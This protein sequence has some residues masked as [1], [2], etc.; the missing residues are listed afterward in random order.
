MPLD[1]ALARRCLKDSDFNSLFIEGLGWDR[2]T[3]HLDVTVDDRTHSL[4]AVAQKR[5]MVAFVWQPPSGGRIP[6]YPTRRKVERKVAKSV[7]EHLIVYVDGAR[8]TQ[9][10]Q[11]VKREAGKPTACREHTYHRIQPGDALIQKLQ[12]LA[13]SIEDEEGLTLFAVTSGVRAGFDVEKV[14]KRFYDRFKTEH[15]AFTKFLKG[16]PDEGLQ[17]WYVSVM[18]N[19][20]MFIYF[21]QKKGFLDGDADY[22]RNK[23]AAS[24]DRGKDRYYRDFL[25]HLFFEGFAKRPQDRSA[26]TNRLLGQVPYLNGGLFLKHQIEEQ[27]GRT[28]EIPDR[29]FEKIFA[30]FDA[31]RWHLDERPLRRDDEINPDVLGYIFEKY[32]NQKQMG[33]YYTK[34]DITGYISQNTVIPRLFDMARAKCKVAFE[35]DQAVWRLLAADP[36]RYIYE[37]VRRGVIAEDGSIV[38]EKDLP[39]FVQKGMHDPKARLFDKRYNLGKAHIPPLPSAGEGG[40][41]GETDGPNLAL[42]TETWR[43]YVE[44]RK[45][46]LDLRRKIA[47]GEVHEI[48]DLITLNLDIRQFAQDVVENCEGPDL[49]VAFWNAIQGITVLDP[50][51]GSGA[52]LFAALNILEPLY[53]ACLDRM[54]AF[55]DEWGEAGRKR[56]PNYHKLFTETLARVA[57]HPSRRYFILKSIVIQNLYGVDIMDE[58]VEICKLRLFLKLVAQVD[59]PDR[60]EP[61][62]DID[63]NIRSGNTLVGFATYE[64]VKRAVESKF[65]FDKAL[66]KIEEKAEIAGRAFGMFRK[67]QTEQ[68]MKP[69]DFREAKKDLADRLRALD[70]ELNRYLAAEYAIE[71]TKAAEYQRWLDSHRPFHWFVDFYGIMKQGGFDVVIGNPPFVDYANV[72]GEYTVRNYATLSSGNLYAYVVE[73]SFAVLHRDGGTGMTVPLSLT[74]S[75]NFPSLRSLLLGRK[76]LL[77]LSSYDNIPDRLFTGAKESDNTSKANQQRITIFLSVPA[78]GQQ[79]VLTTPLLRWRAAERDRLFAELPYVDATDLCSDRWLPKVGS[80]VTTAFLRRLLSMPGSLLSDSVSRGS[81]SLVVPRTAGYYIAAYLDEMDRSKQMRICFRT[82]EARDR[83]MVIVNSNVFFWFWRVLGD[84]FDVTSWLLERFPQLVVLDAAGAA[85]AKELQAAL[86]ECTVYKGYR[87]VD[88]PNVN[89]NKRMDLVWR[90]DEWIIKHIAPNLGITPEDFVWAKSSSFLKLAVAKSANFPPGYEFASAEDSEDL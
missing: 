66:P 17:R 48:N 9:V 43:E 50:A 30:F 52:F 19:R 78:H 31:Y 35:G 28:I 62:P 75:R 38:P 51:C 33:A 1:V 64:D 44:R 6:D 68:D 39:D 46:C 10:W 16:I 57:E 59:D 61:L 49:L 13:F 23:L 72:Q 79:R 7:H 65:D 8:T 40:V 56:H 45:R 34:E 90:A 54:T 86:K 41:R 63:F 73:R 36:D 15:A 12:A 88:V 21:V 70:D 80:A 87:G 89:F 5:G 2:Y 29:A 67:M 77:M 81:W 27:H 55:L 69:D 47:A 25:C 11:W 84:G 20:L 18:L 85:L 37:P 32:I 42:P 71:P 82:S 14:T 24:R 83:A 53:E 74:F 60:I 26:A 4:S 22:L 76:S 58:A 3:S